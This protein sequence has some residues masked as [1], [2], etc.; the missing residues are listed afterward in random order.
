M[1]ER[2]LYE[3]VEGIEAEQPTTDV[4]PALRQLRPY[5]QHRGELLDF[6]HQGLYM[7]VSERYLPE[8]ADAIPYHR[9]LAEYFLNKADP[10]RDKGWQGGCLR[11]LRELP[12]H[13]TK[14]EM[15]RELEATL[16]DLRF[17]EVK[18]AA[19]LMLSLMDDYRTA[20][21]S[22]GEAWF[23]DCPIED[24]QTFLSHQSHFLRDHVESI[25][26]QAFNAA[27][28]HVRAAAEA[29]ERTGRFPLR[30]WLRKTRG[31]NRQGHQ[32]AVCGLTFWG[33]DRYRGS[34]QHKA[35]LDVGSDFRSR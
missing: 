25:Y 1:S 9:E 22:H 10:A 32:G 33:H 16:C 24:F 3:M 13:Q 28:Q 6:F 26:Q 27:E 20:R 18:C 11:G 7:A 19:G 17:M 23:D 15:W 5:L 30:S 8:T 34:Y 35:S 12:F 14:G 29:L 4:Y 21:L 31:S 2:E